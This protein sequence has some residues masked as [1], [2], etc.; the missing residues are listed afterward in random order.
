LRGVRHASGQNYIVATPEGLIDLECSA[1]GAVPA[2]PPEAGPGTTWHT[3]HPLEAAPAGRGGEGNS[4]RR[5]A[6]LDRRLGAAAGPW[7]A[8]LAR[9]VLADRGDAE[10]P[11]S[12]RLDQG[13]GFFTFASVVWQLSGEPV[14][15]IAPGPPCS[16]PYRS[17]R[18]TPEAAAAA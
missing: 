14:A 9:S 12:R 1:D 4:R 13:T 2:R 15:E 5:L 6:T 10:H 17:L 16:T 18:L 8:A 11:I 3:N 7:D